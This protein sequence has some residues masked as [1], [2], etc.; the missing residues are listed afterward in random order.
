MLGVI[1]KLLNE[2]DLQ[3]N[4]KVVELA[5]ESGE[6][7]YLEETIIERAEDKRGITKAYV[8]QLKDRFGNAGEKLC[9]LFDY[10]TRDDLIEFGPV[11]YKAANMDE[12]EAW[13]REHCKEHRTA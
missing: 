2:L 7:M 10:I 4:E 3:V 6:K 11:I 13:L 5:K 1:L 9:A 8:L 12:A